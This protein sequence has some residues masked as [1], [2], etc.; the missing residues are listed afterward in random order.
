M[1]TYEYA[2]VSFASKLE[3]LWKPDFETPI[4]LVEEGGLAILVVRSKWE[5]SVQFCNNQKTD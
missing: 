4:I 2:V 1:S 5:E 3:R